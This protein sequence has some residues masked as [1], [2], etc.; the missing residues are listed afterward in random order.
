M[1]SDSLSLLVAPT[2][3]DKRDDIAKII[4][5]YYPSHLIEMLAKNGVTVRG[6]ERRER[7]ADASAELRKLGIN[8]DG[9]PVSPHGLFV[10]AERT[11]Y[12]RSATT[13]PIIHELGHGLDLVL[14]EGV[15]YSSYDVNIR[16]AFAYARDF[17]TPYAATGIDEYFAEAARAMCSANETS[18]PW[19]RVTPERLRSCDPTMY[20]IM[21]E[22]FAVP[23]A[24]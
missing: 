15:Y 2:A 8:V 18:S 7:Y 1:I 12:L 6:L 21:N 14:G 17:V 11:L 9:W 22:I 23:V 3:P 24:A 10:C 13:M 20:D 19:P 5:T 16:R 4:A